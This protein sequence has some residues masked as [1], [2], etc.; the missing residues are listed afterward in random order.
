MVRGSSALPTGVQI[1]LFRYIDTAYIGAR[2]SGAWYG[3]SHVYPTSATARTCP[4]RGL[5]GAGPGIL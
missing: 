2:F 5:P 1:L 3:L 4:C